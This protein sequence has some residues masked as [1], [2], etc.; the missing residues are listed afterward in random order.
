MESVKRELSPQ[1]KRCV[2]IACE[3]GASNWLA[4]LPL[5]KQGFT[6]NRS[7]FMD[8]I[9]LR[10][11]RELRGLPP[12][13]ACSQPFTIT[14]ALNCKKGGFVHIRHDNIRDFL[15]A[16]LQIVQTDVQKEPPLQQL[17]TEVIPTNIGNSADAAR[18]D[19]RAKGFWRSGQDAYFDVR[20]TNPLAASAMKIPLSKVYDRHEKEKKNSTIIE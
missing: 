3:K 5:K 6:L 1:T 9:N 18:L 4:V 20:V 19:I 16:L 7:Q 14:H 2:E 17:Q 13:C 11:Y 10:Y 12:T 8:A 15:A